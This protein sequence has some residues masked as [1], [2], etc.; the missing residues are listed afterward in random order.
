MTIWLRSRPC[1]LERLNDIWTPEQ[2]AVRD[3]PSDS[4]ILREITPR[5]GAF[6][7]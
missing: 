3:Q 4:Q 6:R 7:A 1:L 2:Q 5:I